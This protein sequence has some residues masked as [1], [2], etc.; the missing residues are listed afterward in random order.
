MTYFAAATNILLTLLLCA[1]VRGITPPPTGTVYECFPPPPTRTPTL[2]RTPTVT[3]TTGTTQLLGFV[4]NVGAVR[5]VALGGSSAYLGSDQFGLSIVDWS[6]APAAIG[7]ARPPFAGLSVAQAGNVAAVATGSNLTIINISVPAVPVFASTVTAANTTFQKVAMVGSFA[8]VIEHNNISGANQVV[9]FDVTNPASPVQGTALTITTGKDI[10]AFGSLLYVS[11]CIS[12]LRILGTGTPAAPNLLSTTALSG[13]ACANSTAVSGT[14][15]Y[16]VAGTTAIQV[17]NVA[18]PAAPAALPTF[19]TTA[20]AVAASGTKLY[21]IDGSN[22]KIIDITNPSS[23]SVLSTTGNFGAQSVAASGTKAFLGTPG[24][25]LYEM[26]VSNPASPSQIANLDGR[27]TQDLGLGAGGSLAAVATGGDLRVVDTSMPTAPSLADIFTVA[28]TTFQRVAVAN[29]FAYAITITSG[30]PKLS[31]VDLH[32]PT[33]PVLGSQQAL[34]TGRWVQVVGTRLYLADCVGGLR[35]YDIS[36]PATPV[37]LS[38]TLL[39]GS[40]CANNLAVSGTVAYVVAGTGAVQIFNVANPAA[41]S[42]IGTLTTTVNKLSV[43]GTRLYVIDD[44]SL[45]IYDISTPGSPNLLGSMG[46][47]GASG[48]DSNGTTVYLAVPGVSHAAVGGVFVVDAS[49]GASPFVTQQVI[50][51]GTTHNVIVTTIG[52]TPV[53][54]ASDTAADVDVISR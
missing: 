21:A 40:A 1:P 49:N 44:S 27:Y 10:K 11:D 30:A 20:N 16:V 8:Y 38:Q 45:K 36:T 31:V 50:V 2:T 33:A 34:T 3:P 5:D 7:G 52:A 25:G 28:S 47:S 15:A 39:S 9:P 14:T 26:D 54:V 6:G 17:F 43:S 51:P 53:V 42:S 35:I 48:V 29:Q 12:G 46:S 4:S 32:T 18:N 22:F 24:N 19:V 13:S 23:L 37:A 41:P